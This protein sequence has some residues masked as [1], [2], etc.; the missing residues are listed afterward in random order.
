MPEA[1][2]ARLDHI[3]GNHTAA[4]EHIIEWQR[5]RG[6]AEAVRFARA[7]LDAGGWQGY[8]RAAIADPAKSKMGRGFRANF[9]LVLGD[10]D[11]AFALLH[12]SVSA[13][14]ESMWVIVAD[15]RFEPLYDDP[16]YA[17]LVKRTGFME[18]A[19]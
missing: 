16:R 3:K 5:L 9:H 4:I 2:P 18:G 19:E 10:T 13:H 11:A 14:D 15:P 1:H 12:E 7:E 8:M 6:D 17:E